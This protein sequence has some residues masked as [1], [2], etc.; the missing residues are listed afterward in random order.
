MPEPITEL[1]AQVILR[2]EKR[3]SD[4][5]AILRKR[6]SFHSPTIWFAILGMA[7]CQYYFRIFKF[8]AP[9]AVLNLLAAGF[10]GMIVCLYD[11]ARVNRRLDA[12]IELLELREEQGRQSTNGAL[13]NPL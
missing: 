1:D 6:T 12:V 10:V 13:K 2:N 11:C 7:A 9:D 5:K 3:L 8:E 4:I